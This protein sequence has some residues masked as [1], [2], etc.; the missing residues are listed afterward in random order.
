M[1][2]NH[3]GQR[4][5]D[6]TFKTRQNDQWADVKTADLFAGKN[7]V[8]FSLPGAY[9]PTCSSTHLR[10]SM[11]WPKPSRPMVLTM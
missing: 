8:A 7:I 3:E 4:V 2:T 6:V 10:V 5:P 11:R 9:T 1:L